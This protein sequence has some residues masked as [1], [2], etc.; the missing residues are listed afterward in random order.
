MSE[1]RADGAEAT[2]R[3]GP[4]PLPMTL[5]AP[6][7]AWTLSR[8]ALPNS[9][10]GSLTESLL[11]HPGARQVLAE[12]AG[13]DPQALAQAVDREVA[14]RS[15]QLHEGIARY[16][17]HGYRRPPPL[18]T[19]YLSL[20]STHLI[21]FGEGRPAA[22]SERPL[23]LVPSLVN[24]GYILDLLPRASLA[25][26]LT[27][28]KLRAYLLEWGEPGAAEASFT[29]TDYVQGRLLP[30]VD[31][32]R[33]R[34]GEA[35]LLVGYC[36]GG[37]L[38]LAA[39]LERPDAVAGLALIA[40]P[41]DFHAMATPSQRLLLDWLCLALAPLIER[42]GVLPVDAI[43]AL[44]VALDPLSA[45][46]KFKRF[47]DWPE[48]SEEAELFVALED[49]LNDGVALSGPVAREALRGWFLDNA[50]KAGKWRVAGTLVEPGKLQVPLLLLVPKRDRIVAPDAALALAEDVA[51]ARLI[52]PD[53]GH[54]GT[55]V[56]TSAPEA[57]WQPLGE[58]LTALPRQQ[59]AK[60]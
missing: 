32:V 34:H 20:G 58:W 30:S 38:T 24:K 39:A 54:I 12:V 5:A 56:G 51:Q 18:S 33:R 60:R 37:L 47:A 44:F 28:R 49:W 21:D 48:E 41:W 27:E 10:P 6:H 9:K 36:M 25:R 1:D 29:I 7:L 22:K 26:W 59:A 42:L 4:R 8:L 57:A 23:I 52:Q 35:P 19:S 15:R 45:Y 14:N 43:Q 17:R 50:P 40:T 16:H 3:Q 53:L 55:I 2:A 11:P 13:S 31:A 46:R